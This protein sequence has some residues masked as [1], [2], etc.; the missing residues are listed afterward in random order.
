MLQVVGFLSSDALPAATPPLPSI[1]RVRPLSFTHVM[2]CLLRA[3]TMFILTH[4][5]CAPLVAAA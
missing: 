5:I 1:P 4:N 3:V 2:G